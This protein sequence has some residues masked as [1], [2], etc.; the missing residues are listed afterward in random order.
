MIGTIPA[1]IIFARVDE[2]ANKWQGYPHD[3]SPSETHFN[4]ARNA[5]FFEKNSDRKF[6]NEK[7]TA[8]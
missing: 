1:G 3:G 7:R 2:D 6:A 5:A 4:A 8:V